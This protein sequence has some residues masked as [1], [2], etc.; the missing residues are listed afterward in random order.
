MLIHSWGRGLVE[1]QLNEIVND[2]SLITSG[3]R[4]IELAISTF[5]L[6][7]SVSQKEIRSEETCTTLAT[8]LIKF[9]NWSTD[10]EATFLGYLSLGNLI[11]IN[12]QSVTLIVKSVGPLMEKIARNKSAALAKL[13]EIATELSEKF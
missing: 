8:N 11:N 1:L 4:N 5:F 3:N 12:G 13:S 10:D 2:I 6:N 7:A 9:L